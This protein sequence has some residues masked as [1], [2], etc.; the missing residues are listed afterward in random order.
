SR[1][2]T[3]SGR[4]AGCGSSSASPPISAA[5]PRSR[6]CNP[7]GWRRATATSSAAWSAARDR[8]ASPPER[9]ARRAKPSQQ[10]HC[11]RGFTGE[12]ETMIKHMLSGVAL[13]A[14][15]ALSGLATAAEPVLGLAAIDLQN[16]FFVRM[17]E[18]GDTAAQDYGVKATWQSAEGSLEKQVAIIE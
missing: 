15:L 11:N 9:G 5:P 3:W 10:G 13:T 4:P 8:T 14:V 12:D 18:A 7:A 2:T 6:R 16:S 17:K 1:T